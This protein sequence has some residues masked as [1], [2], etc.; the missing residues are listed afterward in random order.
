MD[1]NKFLV[2]FLNEYKLGKTVSETSR[3]INEAFGECSVSV[4]TAESWFQRFRLGDERLD[5]IKHAGRERSLD[6]DTLREVVEAYP[7]TSVRKLAQ[8]VGKPSQPFPDTC[9]KL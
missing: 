5:D 3:N 2:I 8:N 7:R 9:V 1:K 4:H 6:D